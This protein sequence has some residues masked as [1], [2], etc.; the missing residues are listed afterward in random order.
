MFLDFRLGELLCVIVSLNLYHFGLQ[1]GNLC[2]VIAKAARGTTSRSGFDYVSASDIADLE[3]NLWGV[4]IYLIWHEIEV[5]DAS[6]DKGAV[7]H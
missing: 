4:V 3:I 6:D 2:A 5:I 7:L 1:V